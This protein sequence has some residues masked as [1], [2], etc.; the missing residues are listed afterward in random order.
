VRRRTASQPDPISSIRLIEASY[1]RSCRRMSHSLMGRTSAGRN[2]NSRPDHNGR[3]TVE[4]LPS[5]AEGTV[6]FPFA[7]TEEG[8]E[9]GYSQTRCQ[10]RFVISAAP[11]D[12]Q[13]KAAAAIHC[14]G[15]RAKTHRASIRPLNNLAGFACRTRARTKS[16]A[17]GAKRKGRASRGPAYRRRHELVAQSRPS[18]LTRG[19]WVKVVGGRSSRS[20]WRVREESSDELS[21]RSQRE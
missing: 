20:G 13:W 6:A 5:F 14:W 9:D 2:A 12:G 10:A 8:Q 18:G 7:L 16:A 21:P 19:C 11:K 3:N 17:C 4:L 15:V 1:L